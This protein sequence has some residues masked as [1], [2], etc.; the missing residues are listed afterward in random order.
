VKFK[1]SEYQNELTAKKKQQKTERKLFII[2]IVLGLITLF[3]IYK[4]LKN[5]VVKQK[6]AALITNLE[7]EKEKKEHLLSEKEL[8]T[9]KLKQQQ[10]KHEIA[11]KNRELT[12][13][14]LYLT[15]RN[16]LIQEIVKSLENDKNTAGNK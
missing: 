16:E 8:E 7:L 9:N 12:A 4:A 10:L 2:A 14:T 13:Q 1:V 6:Q 11:E 5:K 3:S 15:N